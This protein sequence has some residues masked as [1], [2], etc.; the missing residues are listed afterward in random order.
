MKFLVSLVEIEPRTTFPPHINAAR[1]TGTL[2]E[3]VTHI[4]YMNSN[5]LCVWCER[6]RERHRQ[7]DRQT[8]R[9]TKETE[10]E[11]VCAC[12]RAC[13][14]TYGRGADDAVIDGRGAVLSHLQRVVLVMWHRGI[15]LRGKLQP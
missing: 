7:T 8:D 6:E 9:Q 12:V 3:I 15:R 5:V 1:T 2:I 10:T 13:P 4:A 14:L 11:T